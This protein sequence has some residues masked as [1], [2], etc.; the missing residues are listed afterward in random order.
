M[1]GLP[2]L[3]VALQV[4]SYGRSRS[5]QRQPSTQ[6]GSPASPA[7]A[8]AGLHGAPAA[9]ANLATVPAAG[10]TRRVSRFK[11]I[12]GTAAAALKKRSPAAKAAA[13][14]KPSG[15]VGKPLGSSSTVAKQQ[16]RRRRQQQGQGEKPAGR[17]GALIVFCPLYCRTGKC[18]R[19]NK[20]CPY[21]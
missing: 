13:A 3:V 14:L 19:R 2:C 16:Q 18:E 12:S 8:A 4:V 5:L 15:G 20:G 10:T 1:P 11:L 17:G 21:K 6:L 7:A 9:A